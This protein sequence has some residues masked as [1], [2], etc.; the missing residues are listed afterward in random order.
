[1]KLHFSIGTYINSKCFT[2][3]LDLTV[4]PVFEIHEIKNIT[5]NF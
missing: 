2:G 5:L 4:L 1:M 3:I